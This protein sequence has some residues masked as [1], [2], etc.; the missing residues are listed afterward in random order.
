LSGNRS[1]K[2]KLPIIMLCASGRYI[3]EVM[4]VV[5]GVPFYTAHVNH[6][7]IIA[8]NLFS[9]VLACN[10]KSSLAESNAEI[11]GAQP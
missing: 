5:L 9:T 1:K 11:F 3:Y 6:G 4:R 10:L 7:R 2:H 8:N